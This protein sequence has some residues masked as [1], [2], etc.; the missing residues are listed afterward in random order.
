MYILGIYCGHDANACL[1]KDG[2]LIVT[3]EKERLTREKG[4]RGSADACIHYCLETAGID[5]NEID[6][7]ATSR[8]V[9]PNQTRSRRFVSGEPYDDEKT[10][11]SR[12]VMELFGHPIPAYNIQHH[13]GHAACAFYLS[14]FEDAAILS[15]DGWGDF[16]ATLLGYAKQNEIEILERPLCNLGTVWTAFCTTLGFPA[17]Y[18]E[19]KVMGLS[20]YGE[21]T[22]YDQILEWGSGDFRS[23]R[24]Q[25][26]NR[27]YGQALQEIWHD[28]SHLLY[29]GTG[30]YA[31]IRFVDNEDEW[32]GVPLFRGLPKDD[33]LRKEARDIAS[34]LQK[35][36][37]DILIAFAQELYMRT[38]SANLCLVGGVG[39]NCVANSKILRETPFDS[40]FIPPATH[41][42]G[43]AAGLA[44]YLYH[45]ILGGEARHPLRHAYLGRTYTNSDWECLL[46]GSGLYVQVYPEDG[47]QLAQKTAELIEQGAIVAWFQGGSEWGP[48][49]LGHR[50]ILCDPRRGQMKDILNSRVKHREAFRP[51]APSVLLEQCSDYF[52]WDRP[53]PFMLFVAKAKPDKAKEIPAVLHV[54]GTARLQTVTHEENGIYCDVIDYFCR[55]TGV[56][57]I[58]NTSFNVAG[59][60]IVERPEEALHCFTTTDIDYLVAHNFI[61]SKSERP[62]DD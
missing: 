2:E 15:V 32:F 33:P 26:K 46:H 19:G 21:P 35:V 53:S 42:G 1:L 16:T 11:Y 4:D 57:M 23:F 39:L 62:E 56:P 59:E 8:T 5:L 10:L 18:S 28:Q 31:D 12:H 20:A 40:V 3:I 7:I 58:L 41:D 45:S 30:G 24:I 54:D 6:Y 9:P 60:P 44:L 51:F 38:P 48:R 50:S 61:I 36:T 52:Y 47:K 29:V 55:S 14:D 49:A 17:R 13:L 22:Y 25:D 37:E 43:L 27:T 34:S